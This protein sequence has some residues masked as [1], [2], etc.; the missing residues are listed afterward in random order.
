MG[1]GIPG[2]QMGCYE[3]SFSIGPNKQQGRWSL[4]VMSRDDSSSSDYTPSHLLAHWFQSA[5]CS[6]ADVLR[7]VEGKCCIAVIHT[8]IKDTSPHVMHGCEQT[9][10][11]GCRS[12]WSDV[13]LPQAA[14]DNMLMHAKK[15]YYPKRLLLWVYGTALKALLKYYVHSQIKFNGMSVAFEVDRYIN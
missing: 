14:S 12:F 3:E 15:R 7:H 2:V 1:G 13:V 11:A 8:Q 9:W 5:L 10:R 6:T 4:C